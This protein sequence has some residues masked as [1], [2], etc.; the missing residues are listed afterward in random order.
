MAHDLQ[1]D[2]TRVSGKPST[3]SKISFRL[4]PHV[5]PDSMFGLTIQETVR[6]PYQNS[7]LFNI[8]GRGEQGDDGDVVG[9][10]HT[11]LRLMLDL[12]GL[13]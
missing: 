13:E 11:H 8:D 6:G 10:H 7:I 2:D 1:L 9:G 5:P 4:F 12:V 3:W